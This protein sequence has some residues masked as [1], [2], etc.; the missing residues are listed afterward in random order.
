MMII[1]VCFKCRNP[2]KIMAAFQD[3]LVV[4]RYHCQD[5]NTSAAGFLLGYIEPKLD[6]TLEKDGPE[7][8]SEEIERAKYFGHDNEH[9]KLR[10]KMQG[11]KELRAD[12]DSRRKSPPHA[13]DGAAID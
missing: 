4:V 6:E 13:T 3:G 9:Y 5:C 1:P 12:T 8:N 11:L 10:A 2:V 7:V